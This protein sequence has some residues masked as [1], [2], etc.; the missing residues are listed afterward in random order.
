MKKSEQKKQ[1]I[2]KELQNR[3]TTIIVYI[4]LR[5]LVIVSAVAQAMH[6]NWNNVFLCILTL[7]LFTFY[8][9]IFLFCKASCL[10]LVL[11]SALISPALV[12]AILVKNGPTIS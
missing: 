11:P 9:A 5:F 1:E 6:G 8:A 4:V 2:K 7:I 10:A 3:R 12:S